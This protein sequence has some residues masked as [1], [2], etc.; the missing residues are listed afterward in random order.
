MEIEELLEKVKNREYRSLLE[1]KEKNVNID[2]NIDKKFAIFKDEKGDFNIVEIYVNFGQCFMLKSE[3]QQG[4]KTRIY[5]Y[6]F[7]T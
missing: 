2:N 6:I 4:E 1:L 5:E 3:N 7:S